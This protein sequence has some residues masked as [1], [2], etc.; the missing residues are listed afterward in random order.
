MQISPSAVILGSFFV[1]APGCLG[2]SYQLALGAAAGWLVPPSGSGYA[3]GC[4]SA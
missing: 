1:N 4:G 2:I 3:L